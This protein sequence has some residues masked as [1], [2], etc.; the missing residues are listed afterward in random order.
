M[1]SCESL[2]PAATATTPLKGVVGGLAV[3]PNGGWRRW[4]RRSGECSLRIGTWLAAIRM[5]AVD[6]GRGVELVL[7]RGDELRLGGPREGALGVPL[8]HLEVVLDGL[9]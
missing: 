2:D 6:G 9:D 1:K 3:P 7:V 5:L 4:S 8:G